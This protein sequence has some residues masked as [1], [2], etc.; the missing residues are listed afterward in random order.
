VTVADA[1][2]NNRID[3]G[4]RSILDFR[5]LLIVPIRLGDEVIGIAEV[6]STLSSN[7]EGGD[8]LFLASVAELIADLYVRN[9]QASARVS[10]KA[11]TPHSLP[12][13]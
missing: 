3:V 10:S 2:D 13:H 11:N 7:F 6:F 5:S 1:E 9:L 4:I 12:S 8:I